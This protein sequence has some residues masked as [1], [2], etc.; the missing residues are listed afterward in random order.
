MPRPRGQWRD[1]EPLQPAGA[2]ELS[3]AEPLGF[4]RT[5]STRWQ[6]PPALEP[7]GHEVSITAPAGHVPVAGAPVTGYADPPELVWAA[8]P[9]DPAEAPRDAGW[10]RAPA[11]A[12][13][14]TTEPAPVVLPR[15]EVVV[16]PLP[17]PRSAPA[18]RPEQAADR[19]AR[20]RPRRRPG[21]VAAAAVPSCGAGAGAGAGGGRRTVRRR[22]VRRRRPR[23][24]AGPPCC[25]RRPRGEGARCAPRRD[26][27]APAA[28]CRT[29]R[30]GRTN[31]RVAPLPE[32][33]RAAARGGGRSR[34][35][36]LSGP[37][38]ARSSSRPAAGRP[39]RDR[40][41]GTVAH[42]PPTRQPPARARRAAV[43]ARRCRAH[44]GCHRRA[45]L[46]R[47]PSRSRRTTGRRPPVSVCPTGSRA[48]PCGPPR[49]S[50]TTCREPCGG[51]TPARRPRRCSAGRSST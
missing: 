41:C 16:E 6:V 21:P 34:R 30:S 38:G 26:D 25:A 46:R 20:A 23:R 44:R 12:E 40:R 42:R 27:A 39:R 28:R 33:S 50:R 43:A 4:V 3:A 14:P 1:V 49:P 51:R 15:P 48:D 5:L 19:D 35:G 24:P 47:D 7:L 11:R 22:V 8:L 32:P 36:R 18:A 2:A 10:R 37:A 9:E 45:V 31:R 29:L 13:Q 17:A